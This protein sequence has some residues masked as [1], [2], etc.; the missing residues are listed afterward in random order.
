MSASVCTT[1]IAGVL[2]DHNFNHICFVAESLSNIIPNFYYKIIYKSSKEWKSWLKKMCTLYGWSHTKSPLIWQEI[3]I[4]HSNINY[5]GSSYQFWEFLQQYYD[6]KSQLTREDLEAL[7]ADLL[8]AHDIKEEISKSPDVQ[9]RRRITIVG[10]GRSVCA[11][12]VCQLLM[13]KELWL[14]HGILIGLYDEP[15][16]FFKIKKIYKDAGGVG[17]GLNSV[18]IL[19]NVPEGL[20]DCHILIYLDSLLREEY[21]GTDDLL[22]RN[23]KDIEKLSMQINEYAP[24]Y[25]KVLFC[26][27][28]ITCF[29]ANI[30]HELVTKVPSTNIVAVSSHYGLELIYPLVNSVGFTLQ[31]FGCPPVWGY[32]GINQFVD[33]DHMIQKVHTYPATRTQISQKNV[34][35]PIQTQEHSELRWFF[36]MSHNKKPY[37]DNLKRKALTQY[38]VGRSEDFPKCKAICDL[39]KLWYSKKENIEDEIISLGIASDGSFGIPKGLVFSQ[40]VYLKVLADDSRV[41]IPFTDF[42][43][44]NMPFSI[45]QN[46][47]DTATIIKEQI[48]K[49]KE[50]SEFKEKF[51]AT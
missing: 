49:L 14:T 26:S 6:I 24:S 47:I 28:G 20:K 46:F 19:N 35:L 13:T 11:E 2:E 25:M 8:F 32:L 43:M 38:L 40:P 44:P 18:M 37:V 45:F 30:M 23:Y 27:M 16:C 42:P 10:A 50:N 17:A 36:Y 33:V 31:N 48:I 4:T 5:V 51:S 34:L 7:Q 22:Q 1:V 12:L 15:G 3:G 21:E 39:L 41:W 9:E 29:Y